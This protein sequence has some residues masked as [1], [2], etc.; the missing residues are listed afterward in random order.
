MK[1]KVR[2]I[3][4][5]LILLLFF[6]GT[7]AIFTYIRQEVVSES[8]EYGTAKVVDREHKAKSRGYLCYMDMNGKWHHEARHDMGTHI[9]ILEYNEHRYR[10]NYVPA[11]VYCENI[12]EVPV[13]FLVSEHRDGSVSRD[14]VAIGNIQL[15]GDCIVKEIK[16]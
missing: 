5:A 11:Y 15:Y 8:F 2:D 1:Y 9:V 4:C 12:N 3:I 13:T 10:I 6:A 16:N 14:L 7:F